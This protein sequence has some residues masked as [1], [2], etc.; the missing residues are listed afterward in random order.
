MVESSEDLFS[1][2]VVGS[3]LRRLAAFAESVTYC[4]HGGASQTS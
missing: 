3:Y 4:S 1:M 2:I